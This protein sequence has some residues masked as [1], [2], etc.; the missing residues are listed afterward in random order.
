MLVL[1]VHDT[2]RSP[3]SPLCPQSCS[4]PTIRP[5]TRLSSRGEEN[6]RRW[7]GAGG[8]GITAQGGGGEHE[9]RS[10]HLITKSR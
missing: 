1:M 3:H 2:P 6:P 8:P 9:W 7:E 4:P 5:P 10:S